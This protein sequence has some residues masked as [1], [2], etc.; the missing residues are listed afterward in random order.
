[1]NLFK[2]KENNTTVS[3]EVFAGITTFMTMA[4]ILIVNP[5]MLSVTGMDKGAIFTATAI[6]SA[7]GCIMMAL[8]ANYPFAL[9]PGIGL[10]AYFAYTVA[11]QYG[12]ELALLAVFIEGLVFLSFSF[13]NIREAIFNAIPK[14]LK[15][16]VSVG[17]GVFIT[18]IGLQ[19]AGII[20]QDPDTAVALGNIKS[21]GPILTMVGVIIMTF[22]T[23]KR[24][25]GGLFWGILATWGL[26][27]ICLVAGYSPPFGIYVGRYHC[28]ERA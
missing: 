9:A 21:I 19:N 14:N 15:N 26:G 12:W 23:I 16:A 6:A 25:K 27:I 28:N 4:Y 8:L 10:T 20:T 24:V 5:N 17:L 11:K 2:L 7:I 22:L 13:F 18:F 3:T 1:M